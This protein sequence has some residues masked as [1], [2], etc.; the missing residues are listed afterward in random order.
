MSYS[1]WDEQPHCDSVVS[2]GIGGHTL[3]LAGILGLHLI[4]LQE[5]VGQDPDPPGVGQDSE[6]CPLPGQ[7]VAH[8]ALHLAGHHS[9]SPHSRAHVQ[10]GLQHRSRLCLMGNTESTQ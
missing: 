8:G 2:V 7:V 9:H 6:A 4:D 3:V 5:G 1:T 10:W